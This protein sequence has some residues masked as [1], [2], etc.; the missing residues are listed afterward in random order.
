M[1]KLYLDKHMRNLILG[2]EFDYR[3]YDFDEFL[4]YIRNSEKYILKNILENLE[5][6]VLE[7]FGF[8]EKTIEI[9]YECE[10]EVRFTNKKGYYL[11]GHENIEWV[12][13]NF[14]NFVKNYCG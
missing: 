9:I 13:C 2:Y 4:F 14:E 8:D 7:R 1:I 6:Y 10:F 12:E 11:K 3:E 5:Y